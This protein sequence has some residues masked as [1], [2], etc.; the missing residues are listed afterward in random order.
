MRNRRNVFIILAVVTGMAITSCDFQGRKTNNEYSSTLSSSGG[1]MMIG[2]PD[3]TVDEQTQETTIVWRNTEDWNN[4]TEILWADSVPVAENVKEFGAFNAVEREG[5][6]GLFYELKNEG[7]YTVLHCYFQMPADVLQNFWLASDETAIVDQE[8][9]INYRAIRSVPE[10]GWGKYFAVKSKKGD[11]LDFQIYFPKLPRTTKEIGIYGVPNWYMRGR[12]VSLSRESDKANFYDKAPEYRLPKLVKE[13][14]PNYTKSDGHA[15]AVYTDA[16]L[17][18][19]VKEGTMALWRTPEATYLAMAKEQVWMRRYWGF[20]NGSMLVDE[21]GNVY[22][23][24]E[25]LG[26]PSNDHIFWLE[27][28]SGDHMA[29]MHVFEPLSENAKS[30]SYIEPDG[31]PFDSWGANWKGERI[32]HL[33]I[34]ELRQNQHLFEYKER[35]VVKKTPIK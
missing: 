3:I 5:L 32:M 15:W 29:F 26:F 28:Y 16:H 20:S 31:E 22:Q 19:P 8:T 2:S 6:V 25:V 30:I 33:N 27:G 1:V 34:E 12:K 24:K 11:V 18:Q 35:K 14:A 13:E 21:K 7:E 10:C 9:G 23:L 4:Q 17:I